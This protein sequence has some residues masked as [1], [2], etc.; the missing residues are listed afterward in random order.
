MDALATNEKLIQ[1]ILPLLGWSWSFSLGGRDRLLP[2][3]SV[4][5][6]A[7]TVVSCVTIATGHSR[8]PGDIWCEVSLAWLTAENAME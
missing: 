8:A 1:G 3:S 6:S 7:I 4:S 2:A 5:S